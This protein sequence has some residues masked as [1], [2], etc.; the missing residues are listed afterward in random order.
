MFCVEEV[1]RVSDKSRVGGLSAVAQSVICA[2]IVVPLVEA[3]AWA[4][5]REVGGENGVTVLAGVGGAA[6]CGVYAFGPRRWLAD[7]D[8][9]GRFGRDHPLV[10]RVICGFGIVLGLGLA[11]IGL[12]GG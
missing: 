3:G 12:A 4:G 9:A 5:L 11:A 1:L 7:P 8:I 6:V 2:L 10:A